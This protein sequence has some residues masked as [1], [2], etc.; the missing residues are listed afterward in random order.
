MSYQ[1]M[2]D[3]DIIVL[4]KKHKSQFRPSFLPYIIENIHVFRVFCGFADALWA[5]G[6][7]YYSSR[8]IGEKMRFDHDVKEKGSVFKL[9]DHATPDLGRLYA[10]V[11]PRKLDMFSYRR[12]GGFPTYVKNLLDAGEL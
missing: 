11:H 2:S 9:N 12:G 10:I 7:R 5:N 4:A 6:R 3:A 8:T 1:M